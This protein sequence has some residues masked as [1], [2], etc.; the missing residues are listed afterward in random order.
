MNNEIK[1][2]VFAY[3]FKF[4]NK[5]KYVVATQKFKSCSE[6][7]WNLPCGNISTEQ[8]KQMLKEEIFIPFKKIPDLQDIVHCL[9]QGK[10]W[11]VKGQIEGVTYKHQ[12][13]T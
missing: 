10:K 7:L 11:K 6:Y 5:D 1:A 4:L 13:Q 12:E 9:Y 2:Y 3:E 8:F